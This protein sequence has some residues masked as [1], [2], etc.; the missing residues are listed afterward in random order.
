MKIRRRPS[1]APAP[2][3]RVST[4]PKC[5]ARRR[6]GTHCKHPAGFR[7]E[8]PGQ[9]RCYKHGG[10]G[11]TALTKWGAYTKIHYRHMQ[12]VLNQLAKLEFNAMDLIPEANLLRA[13]TVDYINRYNE[14]SE[15]LLAWYEDPE[16]NSRPRRIMDI[17]DASYLI[18][19]IS[20]VVHRMHQIQSQG[21]ISLDTFKR[22][23]EHMGMIVA[24]HV[25][26]PMTLNRIETE[27]MALA[28]DAKTPPPESGEI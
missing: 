10:R 1:T 12:D 21:A 15:A 4:K 5:D 18:E 28:L 11:T 22:V 20:R 6:N 14:F 25:T 7:T 13:L 24:K 16:S 8:H 9:G 17:S 2:A 3:R 27:W 26:D 19:S 23:T